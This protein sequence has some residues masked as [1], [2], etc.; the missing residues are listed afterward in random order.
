MEEVTNLNDANYCVI[1]SESFGKKRVIKKIYFNADS[2][3]YI[4]D[5]IAWVANYYGYL[6]VENVKIECY[7]CNNGL[8]YARQ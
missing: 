8:V 6:I 5:M 1:L 7:H 2:S 4:P 3:N